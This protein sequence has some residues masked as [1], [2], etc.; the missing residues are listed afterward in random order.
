MAFS[1]SLTSI[2]VSSDGWDGLKCPDTH[3]IRIPSIAIET[4]HWTT[5]LETAPEGEQQ[6]VLANGDTTGYGLHG[7][8]TN[9]WDEDILRDIVIAKCANPPAGDSLA[10]V[11]CV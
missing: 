7:D 6:Y 3:P 5:H 10:Y 9:G 11:Y 8:F 2:V 1:F 4:F